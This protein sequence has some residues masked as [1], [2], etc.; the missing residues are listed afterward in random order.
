MSRMSSKFVP[1]VW[2][3]RGGYRA[4]RHV[5]ESLRLQILASTVVVTRPARLPRELWCESSPRLAA[6]CW[7]VA[8][9]SVQ[10]TRFIHT[11]TGD[12][13]SRV[14]LWCC[15]ASMLVKEFI[16]KCSTKA[17]GFS[18]ISLLPLKVTFV[19]TNISLKQFCKA[20]CCATLRRM[21]V[22]RRPGKP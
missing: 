21:N 18:F 16:M 19:V 6:P 15:I 11:G 10:R 1:L 22:T 17:E 12:N 13:G 5:I 9:G 4:P 7:C 20:C 8:S 3:R 14:A 2:G